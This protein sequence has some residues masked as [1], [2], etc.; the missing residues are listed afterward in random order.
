ML[1]EPPES[2]YCEQARRGAGER[3]NDECPWIG[4]CVYCVTGLELC[5]GHRRGLSHTFGLSLIKSPVVA[6]LMSQIALWGQGLLNTGCRGQDE[7]VVEHHTQHLVSLLWLCRS[8]SW[9]C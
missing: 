6:T 3:V 9:A 1:D 7:E 8:S 4:A 5:V 2:Y